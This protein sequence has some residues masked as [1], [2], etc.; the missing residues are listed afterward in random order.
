[1]VTGELFFVSKALT[2]S[3]FGCRTI[4]RADAI[5]RVETSS[6]PMICRGPEPQPPDHPPVR[7]PSGNHRANS[8]VIWDAGRPH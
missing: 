4:I 7:A 5:V 1:M 2:C 8:K 6:S 3:I